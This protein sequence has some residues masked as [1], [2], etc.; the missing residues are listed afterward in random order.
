M[1]LLPYALGSVVFMVIVFALYVHS[2][3][4]TIFIESFEQ[5]INSVNTDGGNRGVTFEEAMQQAEMMTG[6][7]VEL[8]EDVVNLDGDSL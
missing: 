8:E 7:V 6:G 2:L 3:P 5:T 4:P 1:K